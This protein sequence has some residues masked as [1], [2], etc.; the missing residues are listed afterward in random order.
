MS[1]V[2]FNV[3]L[4]VVVVVIVCYIVIIRIVYCLLECELC[5]FFV[6]VGEIFFVY[7]FNIVVGIGDL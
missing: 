5:E 7:I 2:I 3:F 1:L 6:L 4:Y